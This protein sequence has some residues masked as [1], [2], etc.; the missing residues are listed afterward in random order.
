MKK[1]IL[2]ILAFLLMFQ[3]PMGVLAS[4]KPEQPLEIIEEIEGEEP[5]LTPEQLEAIKE[6]ERL[7]EWERQVNKHI[8][9]S[10][11]NLTTTYLVGDFKSGTILEADNIDELV[12]IASTTKILTVY[13]ALDQIK[14]G[15]ISYDDV[16]TID[17]ET[18]LIGGS[19]FKLKEGE[20][21]TVKQLIEAAMI[22][23]GN[24]AVNALAKH[25]AGTESAFVNMMKAKLE[26]LGITNYILVNSSGLPN[27]VINEQNMMT[28]RNLFGL[29][30]A[31]LRDYPE[32]LEITKRS[33]LVVEEREFKEKNTNPILEE[34]PQVDGL[35]TG[36]TGK[37][38]RCMVATGLVRGDGVS[39]GDIRLIGITMGSNS[40]A[41]RYV[42]IKKLMESALSNYEY[43]ILGETQIPIETVSNEDLEPKEISIYPFEEV[44]ILKKKSDVV[45]YTTDL[46]P[47]TGPL[48]SGTKVGSINY[49][50]NGEQ[51]HGSDLVIKE[52]IVESSFL[53][54][55]QIKYRNFFQSTYA[56][57]NN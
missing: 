38:G 2:L 21:V 22:V 41:E 54:K 15:N 27:Y 31:F 8:N 23:S 55:L 17:R 42:A 47:I 43:K 25:I 33:E 28:T 14:A 44:E 57:F 35:K 11:D 19:S 18:H 24:D 12:A 34:M 48:D 45:T 53:K 49:Y 16:V 37:A 40:D 32:M 13:V 3:A 5:V 7:A 30:R 29:S 52:D 4:E 39:N 56:L 9:K 10:V 36:Y 20:T 50:V 51:V 26:S 1:K 46:T 6:A